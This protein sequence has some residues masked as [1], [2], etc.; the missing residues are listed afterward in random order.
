[1]DPQPT[2]YF[3]V[4][5]NSKD[6][7]PDVIADWVKHYPNTRVFSFNFVPDAVKRLGNPYATIA[8]VRQQ[9][10]RMARKHKVDYL[11]MIDDDVF[12]NSTDFIPR[13]VSHGLDLVG[14]CY[15]RCYPNGMY[16]AQKWYNTGSN[17]KEMPYVM[18]TVAYGLQQV[19]MTSGGCMCISK[20]LLNDDRVSFWPLLSFEKYGDT[21][22]DYGFCIKAVKAGYKIYVDGNIKIGHY[23]RERNYKPW[24]ASDKAVEQ[25]W[26]KTTPA[27]QKYIDFRYGNE[28]KLIESRNNSTVLDNLI[29]YVDPS[30]KQ[31]KASK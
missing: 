16:L 11:I 14:G 12:V 23:L 31:E 20:K 28:D 30:R 6:E 13:L 22:E 2:Y 1:L 27:L 8:L 19:A 9:L 24:C 29:N 15:L 17:R 21:S 4:E 25:G 10:I 18:K 3:I 5:N 7:T 26:T